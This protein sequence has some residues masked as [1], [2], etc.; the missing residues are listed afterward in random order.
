M[1]KTV[2]NDTVLNEIVALVVALR[3][4]GERVFGCLL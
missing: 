2:A 3:A 1:D 4:W